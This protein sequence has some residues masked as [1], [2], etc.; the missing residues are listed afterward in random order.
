MALPALAGVDE[1]PEVLA[2]VETQLSQRYGRDCSVECL[3]DPDEAVRR[4]TELRDA[5]EHVALVRAMF[6]TRRS[7]GSPPPWARAR[8]RC[9]SFT[10][11]SP[12]AT[13]GWCRR[14]TRRRRRPEPALAPHPLVTID[15]FCA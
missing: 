10:D 9:S 7:S 5:V 8:S 2:S 14:P 15:A 13:C 4:L 12:K 11:S 1:H 3:A 6:A